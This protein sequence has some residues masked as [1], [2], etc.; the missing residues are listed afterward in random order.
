MEFNRNSPTQLYKL[1]AKKG[2]LDLFDKL[3]KE[4]TFYFNYPVEYLAEYHR[5]RQLYEW[6]IKRQKEISL[7]N[8]LIGACRGF[9]YE[10]IDF[11]LA[12]GAQIGAAKQIVLW[13]GHIE[14]KNYLD[15]KYPG[16]I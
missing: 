6:L 16:L 13:S 4:E 12:K 1:L 15:A 5:N 8:V 9:N 11:L 3:Y 7:S 10:M 2:F 14:L